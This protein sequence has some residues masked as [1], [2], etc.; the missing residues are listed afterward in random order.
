MS[1]FKG[2]IKNV[3]KLNNEKNIDESARDTTISKHTYREN[4]VN[5][6]V[7]VDNRVKYVDNGSAWD[8]RIEPD[9][10]EHYTADHR[11]I[12]YKRAKNQFEDRLIPHQMFTKKTQRPDHSRGLKSEKQLYPQRSMEYYRKDGMAISPAYNYK[13]FDTSGGAKMPVQRSIGISR[14]DYKD[15]VDC[16]ANTRQKTYHPGVEFNSSVEHP[17]HSS[18]NVV[19][20]DGNAF[21]AYG[22][23]PVNTTF[24]NK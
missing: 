6:I 22:Y 16:C 21:V 11:N 20:N 8:H 10:V 9:G 15:S 23:K 1:Q 19:V 18:K 2:Y 4:K 24:F 14:D 3:P 7:N 13:K 12:Y 5:R 17:P